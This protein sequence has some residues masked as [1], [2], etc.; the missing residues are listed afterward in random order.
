MIDTAGIR[1][2][3]KIRQTVEKFSIVKAL[4][5]IELSDSVIVLIDGVEGITDQDASLIGLVLAE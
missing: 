4:Q 1:R 5:A 2:R 3:K